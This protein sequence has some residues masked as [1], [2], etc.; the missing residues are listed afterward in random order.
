MESTKTSKHRGQRSVRG[1]ADTCQHMYM[2]S[3]RLT[4]TH[5][6]AHTETRETNR[7]CTFVHITMYMHAHPD[8][9]QLII[10]VHTDAYQHICMYTDTSRRVCVQRHRLT[11]MHKQAYIRTLICA[12]RYTSTCITL[13]HFGMCKSAHMGTHQHI[14][15]C[16]DRHTLA[17]TCVHTLRHIRSCKCAHRQVNTCVHRGTHQDMY[18]GTDTSAHTCVHTHLCTQGWYLAG[19]GCSQHMWMPMSTES[20]HSSHQ[21]R[22]DATIPHPGPFPAQT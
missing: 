9:H 4:S 11:H 15:M 10:C 22:G 13:E 17:Y 6:C 1:A 16:T 8:T 7:T 18:V 20:G 21:A 14:H 5:L 2:L 3:H 19:H 12:H